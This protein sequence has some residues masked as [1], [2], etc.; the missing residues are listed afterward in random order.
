[1]RLW[2]VV[3]FLFSTQLFLTTQ[4]QDQVRVAVLYF[5]NN[6]LSKQEQL[7]PL[8]TGFAE[9]LIT[10]LQKRSGFSIVERHRLNEVIQEQQLSNS[11]GF[12]ASTASRIGRL[13]GAQA[14]V[15]GSFM[16]SFSD[17]LRM[18]IRLIE[19][20]TGKTLLAAEE[21]DDLEDHFDIVKNIAETITDNLDIQLSD[22]DYRVID[23]DDTPGGLQATIAF[24]QGLN[25]EDKGR[26][27]LRKGELD[28]A[29]DFFRQAK[30]QFLK[31]IEISPSFNNAKAKLSVME[32]LI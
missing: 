17:E 7:E 9:M 2:C 27:F 6:S 10:E 8:S 30:E 4:A 32:K 31:A 11:A 20:E 22:E 13:L 14:L 19:V 28:K 5:E 29:A 18:D 26:N 15:L 25:L 21:T 1:M 24:S 23:R 16:N 3:L 12:D